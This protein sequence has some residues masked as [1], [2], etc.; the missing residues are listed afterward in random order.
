[1][2]LEEILAELHGLANPHNVEGMARF[3]INPNGTLGVKMD[4]LH[5]IARRIRNE[6]ELKRHPELAAHNHELALCLWETGIHEA[7]ILAALIADPQR[8]DDAQMERWA[9]DFDSWDLVDQTSLALFSQTP[10]AWD[11][12]SAWSQRSE[13]FVKRA[14]FALMAALA[15]HARQEPDERFLDWLAIIRREARDERPYVKKAVNW[16]LRQVGKRNRT[17]NRAAIETARAIRADGS[18]S[19]RW[20]AA[21]ALRELEGEA[22]QRR[23]QARSLRVRQGPP[24]G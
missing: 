7:R 6:R 14:A 10:L 21:D 20:I 1:M 4:Q 5:A 9:A 17:L 13:E 8:T 24:A 23:L 18:R 3:G 19:G 2:S 16:A 11:K 22:V 15:V 12:V